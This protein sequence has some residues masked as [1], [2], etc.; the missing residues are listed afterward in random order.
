MTLAT[1]YV[2]LLFSQVN[3]N[4]PA[5]H[6]PLMLLSHTWLSYYP[7]CSRTLHLWQTPLMW[8]LW[9]IGH[10]CT[11]TKIYTINYRCHYFSKRPPNGKCFWLWI[12]LLYETVL[13]SYRSH[14]RSCHLQLKSNVSDEKL[15]TK[16]LKVDNHLL[17]SSLNGTS[18]LT[19]YTY[20]LLTM[21]D[22]GFFKGKCQPCGRGTNCW[23]SRQL[24]SKFVCK[25]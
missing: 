18:T 12:C 19:V 11:N 21:A 2:T 7:L 6:L 8:S 22:P 17:G 24:F 13:F 25:N 5:L 9:K 23:C 10:S 3:I 1:S 16:A 4:S 20:L 14:K 15:P